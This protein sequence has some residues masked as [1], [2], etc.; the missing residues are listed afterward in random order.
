M[1]TNWERA[2][3]EQLISVA[4]L[5][6]YKIRDQYGSIFFSIEPFGRTPS[7]ESALMSPT[8]FMRIQAVVSVEIEVDDDRRQRE[9]RK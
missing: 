3:W 1:I 4:D 2:V 7:A 6:L 5:R 9:L 8:E